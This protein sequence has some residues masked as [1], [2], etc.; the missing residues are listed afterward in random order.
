MAAD[1][2]DGF[3][4]AR[5]AALLRSISDVMGEPIPD[6]ESSAEELGISLGTADDTGDL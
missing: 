5:R 6:G 4:T 2:F 3:F 1:D